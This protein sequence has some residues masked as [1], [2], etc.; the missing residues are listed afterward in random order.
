MA[1]DSRVRNYATIVYQESAPAGWLDILDELHI[2]A[3][4]SPL[5]D[6]DLNK[7]GEIKKAHWHN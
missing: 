2:P 6:K 5:H 7:E 1:T 3:F 4:V